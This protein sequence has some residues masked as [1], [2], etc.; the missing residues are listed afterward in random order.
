MKLHPIFILSLILVLL[1]ACAAGPQGNV[2]SVEE[3][4]VTVPTDPPT[5]PPADPPTEPQPEVFTLTFVGD[6]TLGSNPAG[7]YFESSFVNTV[8]DDYGY[9]FANVRHLFEADDFT[10]ANL[11][12]PLT[13]RGT[14]ASKEFVFRGPPAYTA[15][16]TGVEAVTIANNHIRDY[17]EQG[18]EDTR[19]ALDAAGI[20]YG[21]REEAFL[22]KTDSGL[23]IGVFCDDFTFDRDQIKNAVASLREQGAEVVVCAFHWGIEGAYRPE[24]NQIDWAHIAVDAGAD[25]V[26]GHHPHVLQPI[27]YYGNGVIYY[28]LA[29]FAFG[30]NT[31]PSDSDTAII[32]QQIIRDPG[33][34]VRLGETEIIPCSVSSIQGQNNFQPTPLEEGGEAWERVMKKLAGTYR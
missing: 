20:A 8:G 18:W 15:I 17:G 29:N 34:T 30:G 7:A 6:C 31:W 23:T 22:Y 9:P 16:L 25:I 13:E 33:G 28:S 2:P 24:Q 21:G 11:E 27:E 32:R 12:G 10:M 4:V 3:T 5:D 26:Y 1:T 19:A 14:P